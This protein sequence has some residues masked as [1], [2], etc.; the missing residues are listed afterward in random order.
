MRRKKRF[1][2][3]FMMLRKGCKWYIFN[4]VVLGAFIRLMWGLIPLGYI[5]KIS[6]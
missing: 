3:E 1:G 5:K 2:M 6:I 4:M